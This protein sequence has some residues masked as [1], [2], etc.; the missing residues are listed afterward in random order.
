VFSPPSTL[1]APEGWIWF[2]FFIP[3]ESRAAPCSKLTN[4][5][6]QLISSLQPAAPSSSDETVIPP[7]FCRRLPFRS[8]TG[9]AWARLPPSSFFSSLHLR[10]PCVAN[11]PVLGFSPRYTHVLMDAVQKKRCSSVFPF[12]LLLPTSISYLRFSIGQIPSCCRLSPYHWQVLVKLLAT[13]LCFSFQSTFLKLTFIQA[14][15]GFTI[16]QLPAN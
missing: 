1:T 8:E 12:P 2:P 16:P 5:N 7:L 13:L 6:H 14:P 4:R 10:R 11:A 15:P 9:Q 3:Y